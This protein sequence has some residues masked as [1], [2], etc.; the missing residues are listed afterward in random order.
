MPLPLPLPIPE[1]GVATLQQSCTHTS[2]PP[3]AAAATCTAAAD[4]GS[5]TATKDP[6]VPESQQA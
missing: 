2:A 4:K 3:A 5:E 6:Q 1:R